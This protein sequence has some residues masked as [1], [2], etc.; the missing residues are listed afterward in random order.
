[1]PISRVVFGN[2]SVSM[3]GKVACV[4]GT[5]RRYG[6]PGGRYGSTGLGCTTSGVPLAK[7]KSRKVGSKGTGV[8]GTQYVVKSVK[9]WGKKAAKKKAPAK[10]KGAKKARLSNFEKELG[11]GNPLF[12]DPRGLASGARKQF[13]AAHSPG[14]PSPQL[15]RIQQQ[16]RAIQAAIMAA[17]NATPSPRKPRTR[18]APVPFS[19]KTPLRMRGKG[20]SGAGFWD[21]FVPG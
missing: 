18:R 10:R 21:L 12:S 4:P 7:A 20:K 17:G 14:I 3:S 11:I 16:G 9:R 15:R 13:A 8:D 1:M 19:P 6:K 5:K 2:K